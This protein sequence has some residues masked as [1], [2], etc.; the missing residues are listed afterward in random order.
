MLLR[1]GICA[2]AAIMMLVFT[3]GWD[4]PFRYRLNQVPDRSIVASVDF[5]QPDQAAT[6]EAR[7]LARRADGSTRYDQDPA[8][9]EQL[10][11][12][13]RLEIGK[14]LAADTW[15]EVNPDVWQQFQP[16]LAEGTPDPT[17]EERAEQFQR[18]KESL[19]TETALET[20]DTKIAEAMAPLE[21]WGL[22]EELPKEHDGDKEKNFYPHPRRRRFLRRGCPQRA[23]C[24]DQE[25]YALSCSSRSTRS[26]RRWNSPSRSSPG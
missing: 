10:R 15:E 13:L 11:A 18:L 12:E 9:L 5:E 25:R 4:P 22:L 26:S 17:D 23:R 20:F 24:V 6:A 3:R 14:L 19:A 21:E 16:P 7:T 8:P 2:I 1:V